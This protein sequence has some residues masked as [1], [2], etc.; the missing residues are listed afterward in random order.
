MAAGFV[1]GAAALILER[2][3][4][5][6]PR[7]VMDALLRQ[8]TPAVADTRLGIRTNAPLLYIGPTVLYAGCGM[9]DSGRVTSRG[10]C[11]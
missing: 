10:A 6:T 5:A 7:Q 8:A 3:P 11:M 9:R 2:I 1:S 4:S